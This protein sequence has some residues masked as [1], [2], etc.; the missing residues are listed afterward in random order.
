MSKIILILSLFFL[1]NCVSQTAMIGPAASIAMG[2]GVIKASASYG[3]NTLIESQT[4]K[5]TG[6]IFQELTE[7]K[8][9]RICEI[10]HSNSLSEIFFKTQD[11]L[12]CMMN[13][14]S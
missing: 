13:S 11:D 3:V 12:D 8:N 7:E 4:G 6:E 10:H 2:G 14:K 5:T 1:T 9:L